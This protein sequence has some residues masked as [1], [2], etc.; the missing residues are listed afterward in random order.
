MDPI[1]ALSN[2]RAAFQVNWSLSVFARPGV[3]LPM[4]TIDHL[5]V[6]LE[7]DGIR[8]LEWRAKAGGIAQFL[9]S[10]RPN[11]A[12]SF[13]VQRIKGRWQ[14]LMRRSVAKPFRRNFH[15]A[16]VG[17]V[18]SDVL[19]SYVERQPRRHRM[20]DPRV[21]E[22]MRNAQYDDPR[23]DLMRPVGSQRGQYVYALHVVLRNADGW[24]AISDSHLQCYRETIVQCARKHSW[25]LSRIGIVVDH[26]HV[27]LGPTIGDS[28]SD[29]ALSL[30][31]NLAYRQGM[32]R[33][34]EYSY[35]VG[36]YSMYDRDAI[37]R[38][39]ACQSGSHR[40]KVGGERKR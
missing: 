4:E 39:V 7:A 13:V 16:S 38:L 37:R 6:P 1:Y 8:L 30:M 25:R 9:V 28:P 14:Y 11:I 32:T 26:L 24:R 17:E 12:P 40:R 15:L 20:A 18:N 19:E 29:V 35:Y 36:T 21:Q 31:N 2:T 3:V 34:L 27:L 33:I 23:V 5:Q 22:I 10:T